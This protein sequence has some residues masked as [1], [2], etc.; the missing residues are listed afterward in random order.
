MNSWI[1]VLEEIYRP[2]MRPVE[3]T[4]I[5]EERTG[6]KGL[7]DRIQKRIK[8][9]IYMD[10]HREGI[11]QNMEPAK[12]NVRWKGNQIVRFGLMGDTQIGSK[13]TQITHLK[14][15]Y[16]VAE[17]EGIK[18]IYHTGDLTDGLRMRLG[19]EY[20]IYE[21][22]A[23]EM[24]DDV[25]AN[26]PKHKSITTHFIT[27]NHDAAIFKQCGYDIGHTI[28]SKREDME[29]LGRDGAVVALT[30][31]CKLEI[32]HPWDGSAYSLSYK[33]Q[34][35]VEAMEADSK[36]NILAVGHYHKAEYFLYRSVNCFQTGCFQAQ[37]PWMRG[38][39]IASIMG[40]WIVEIE[41]DKKGYIQ[42]IKPEFIPF[43][44]PIKDDYKKYR[45]Y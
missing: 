1:D 2:G 40:G 25:V 42:R 5:V 32:R 43:Y 12:L 34:K 24:V 30:P 41:V 33:I 31:N 13:Y 20:E 4:R 38:K 36:P 8:R 16:D 11:V 28:A 6:V 19:H 3:A 45:R 7:K 18:H 44:A 14:T 29:Y 27:G 23:D 21:P 15:F 10:V 9:N 17:S 35:M 37:T 39:G 26:Y 22:S